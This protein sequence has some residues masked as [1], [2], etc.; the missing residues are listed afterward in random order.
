MILARN[1]HKK[2][3]QKRKQYREPGSCWNSGGTVEQM[4]KNQDP[5]YQSQHF[6]SLALDRIQTPKNQSLSKELIL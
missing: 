5:V 4:K 6:K 2:G 3:L 1:P